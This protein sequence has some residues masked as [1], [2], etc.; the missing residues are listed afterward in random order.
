MPLSPFEPVTCSAFPAPEP[1]P[2]ATTWKLLFPAFVPVVGVA[3]LLDLVKSPPCPATA[4]VRSVPI[5]P[6]VRPSKF[7]EIVA[8]AEANVIK[9]NAANVSNV[10]SWF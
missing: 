4:P 6:I 2:P 10:F 7:C 5:F 3:P 8:C 9:L 1:I